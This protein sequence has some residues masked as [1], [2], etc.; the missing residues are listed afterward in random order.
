MH[1]ATD[2]TPEQLLESLEKALRSRLANVEALTPDDVRDLIRRA[3][4][5]TAALAAAP[6][7]PGADAARR[8]DRIR[9][10][11]DQLALAVRQQHAE[12]AARLARMR[13]GK[14]VLRTYG[15]RA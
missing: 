10:L 2:A 11:H 8:A 12:A 6:P 15:G 4:Q 13:Q 5:V 3:E 14:A 7:K 1:P 9:R